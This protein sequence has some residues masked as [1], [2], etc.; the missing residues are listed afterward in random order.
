[1]TDTVHIACPVCGAKNRVP[2]GKLDAA[3]VCGACKASLSVGEPAQLNERSL[4]KFTRNNDA[5]TVIDFWA[6]WCQPCH[7]MA[8]QFAEAA[9]AMPQVRFAK[10]QTDAYEQAA[11]SYGIRSLPTMV[12]FKHGAE[13]ARV[14][15]AMRAVQI[16]DWVRGL[17]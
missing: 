2:T 1:M 13:V 8:P 12:A 5:L 3:L 14:S 15:G 4:A 7:M 11:A 16:V 10:L 9:K 17:A 6:S